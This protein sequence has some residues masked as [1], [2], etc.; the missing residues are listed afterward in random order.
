MPTLYLTCGLPG[1]GKTTL[2]RRLE[3]VVPALRLTAD[4]WLH[5]LYPGIST[6]EA[7]TGPFR[8]RVERIQWPLALRALLLGSDVVL[9]WGLWS[10]A[11][12]DHYRTAAREVGAQ[13]VLCLLEAPVDELCARISRRN[14]ER[15]AGVFEISEAK[16]RQEYATL[17]QRPTAE[18]LALFDP[19]AP[20]LASTQAVANSPRKVSS[21]SRWLT[22][23]DANHSA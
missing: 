7:E 1:S 6:P 9:D 14:A 4:D 8:E 12:R 13:V 23:R 18:E 22:F 5:Q 10:R 2:A 15:P 16:L 17:L 21:P 3:E 11:E 20:D 19:L